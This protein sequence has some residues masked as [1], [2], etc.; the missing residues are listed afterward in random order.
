[1]QHGGPGPSLLQPTSKPDLDRP[2]TRAEEKE[3]DDEA[4]RARRQVAE[5]MRRQLVLFSD[6]GQAQRKEEDGQKLVLEGV[7]VAEVQE[8]LQVGI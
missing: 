7:S 3:A 2:A 1:M 6:G 5:G 4:V 8:A